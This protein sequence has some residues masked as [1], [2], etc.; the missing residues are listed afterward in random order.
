MCPPTMGCPGAETSKRLGD[1]SEKVAAHPAALRTVSLS[2]QRQPGVHAIPCGANPHMLCIF[3]YRQSPRRA[4][5]K[6]QLINIIAGPG[7]DR[8]IAATHENRV[9]IP[10]LQGSLIRL[11]LLAGIKTLERKSV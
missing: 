7:D 1:R 4:C 2:H 10:R 5:K 11:R 6:I 8:V 3:R 9:P